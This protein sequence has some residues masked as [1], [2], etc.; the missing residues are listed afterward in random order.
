MALETLRNVKEIGGYPVL[1]A[2]TN[3]Y[4]PPNAIELRELL[5]EESFIQ[6]DHHF[7]MIQFKIQMGPIKESGVNGCQVDTI[8]EA[9]KKILEG[10][11][12][13]FPS[14][15]NTKALS[16]LQYAIDSLKLRTED[17]EARGVEGTSQA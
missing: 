14:E 13:Q 8:I 17:R 1:H 10:L 12:E 2:N 16:G 11:N 5:Y 15:Y 6:I 3:D 9:A 7:N 4:P